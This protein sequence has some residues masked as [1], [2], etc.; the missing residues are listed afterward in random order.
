MG[1]TS[2][3]SVREALTE[4]VQWSALATVLSDAIT[5]DHPGLHPIPLTPHLPA[6]TVNILRRKNAY[7]SAAAE[8][9]IELAQ[10]WEEHP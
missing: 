7:L 1:L 8:A 6:R 10:R 9:F 2:S 3:D 5:R 4:V